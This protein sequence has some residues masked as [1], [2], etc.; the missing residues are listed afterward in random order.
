[1]LIACSHRSLSEVR[2]LSD[3]ALRIANC[4]LLIAYSHAVV[5][6]ASP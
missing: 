3:E 5:P 1:L 4:L 6:E 2:K